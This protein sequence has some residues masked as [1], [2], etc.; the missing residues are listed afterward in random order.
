MKCHCCVQFWDRCSMLSCCSHWKANIDIVTAVLNAVTNLTYSIT[1]CL[2]FYA[3]KHVIFHWK[4]VYYNFIL[5][6]CKGLL[7]V[8]DKWIAS[9]SSVK[10]I[11]RNSWWSLLL[12]EYQRSPVKINLC[13]LLVYFLPPLYTFMGRGTDGDNTQSEKHVYFVFL[14]S[15]ADGFKSKRTMRSYVFMFFPFSLTSSIADLYFPMYYIE[16]FYS[17]TPSSHNV[18]SHGAVELTT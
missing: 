4:N 1:Y 2:G 11:V 5:V 6:I 13:I 10:K 7:S 8:H 18:F 12:L 17:S 16:G 14:Y 15:I 9:C 3:A